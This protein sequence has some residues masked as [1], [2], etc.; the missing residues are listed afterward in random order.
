MKWIIRL[1]GLTVFAVGIVAYHYRF[2]NWW[3][4][5]GLFLY[6]DLGMLG[7]LVNTKVGAICYNLFHHLLTA[8]CLCCVGWFFDQDW[9]LILGIVMVSHIGLDRV[10]GYGLKYPDQFKSTHLDKL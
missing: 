10:F 8:F 6:P 7:Y 4:F 5:A 2:D 3:W 1:E 9:L